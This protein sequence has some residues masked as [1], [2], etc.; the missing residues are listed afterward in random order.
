MDLALNNLQS[1][2]CH[3]P[4]QLNQTQTICDSVGWGCRIHRLHLCSGVRLPTPNV[5]LGYDTKQSDC[6]V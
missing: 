3:E 4:K 2:I 6:E 5:C 1:L